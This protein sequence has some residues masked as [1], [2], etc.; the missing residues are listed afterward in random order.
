M[1]LYDRI[2]FIS[3]FFKLL[4]KLCEFEGGVYVFNI[5]GRRGIPEPIAFDLEVV[6]SILPFLVIMEQGLVENVF[7]K[8]IFGSLN[9]GHR[10]KSN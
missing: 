8:N 5:I 7:I 2:G 3:K 1:D 10:M 9:S 4:F 6:D